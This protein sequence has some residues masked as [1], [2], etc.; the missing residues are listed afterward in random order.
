MRNQTIQMLRQKFPSVCAWAAIC[1]SGWLIFGTEP[2]AKLAP[3]AMVPLLSAEELLPGGG[4]TAKLERFDRN[5]FASGSGNLDRDGRFRFAIG[6]TAF[7]KM[8]VPAPAETN[9]NDGL[10]PL[11]NARSC[12]SCHVRD[13]RGH[14]PTSGV[15]EGAAT[16][17]A[18]RISV[19]G[20][21]SKRPA[22]PEPTYGLQLQDAAIPGHRAEGR[23]KLGYHE[24]TLKLAGGEVVSL[25][26]PI[27]EIVDLAYGPL[28]ADVRLSPRI[29]QQMIGLGLLEMVDEKDI[30]A[31]EDRS[32]INGDG[33]SG[34]A[35]RVWSVERQALMVGRLGHKAAMP[36]LRQ[37]ISEALFADMGLS[38][39]LRPNPGGD[40]TTAQSKCQGAPN[41]HTGRDDGFEVSN[42]LLDLLTFY[43]RNVAV[44]P[45]R[46]PNSADA[47]A[48]RK[49]FYVVGCSGCHRP[50]FTTRAGTGP[51]HLRGQVIWPFTDLLLHDMGPGLSDNRKEWMANGQEW[52][53][54]PLWG[55]GLTRLVSGHTQLLH[56]GRARNLTEAILWHGGE[57]QRARD[58][59]A[60]LS[61]ADR[62][63][64]LAYVRSL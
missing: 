17:L 47:I 3:S 18:I 34:R 36:S 53:T 20:A 41:G 22:P 35:N 12:E 27:Y 15:A 21:S 56:D 2:G 13:G 39:S 57:A 14:P 63:R 44:P 5:A 28:A 48:G 11:F 49:L 25:R 30:L 42:K 50:S 40:C 29:A 32:D 55:V 16:S 1:F 58:R 7:R 62:A 6:N 60:Q 61:K 46:L 37:Q 52:R 23:V 43:S 10:G 4:A 38:N 24:T 8:F 45:R 33:I 54:A 59:F 51:V 26:K 31:L 19:P 9:A 64:L